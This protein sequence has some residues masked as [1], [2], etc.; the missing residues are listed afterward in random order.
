MAEKYFEKT[1][2]RITPTQKAEL[3]KLRQSGYNAS[4]LIRLWIAEGLE[5]LKQKKALTHLGEKNGI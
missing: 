1:L 2:V 3:E 5:R 4:S